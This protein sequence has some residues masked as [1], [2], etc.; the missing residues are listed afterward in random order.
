MLGRV[1]ISMASLLSPLLAAAASDGL[2]LSLRS[3]YFLCLKRHAG[4]GGRGN[5]NIL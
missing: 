3:L 4:V 2:Y 1:A 5:N